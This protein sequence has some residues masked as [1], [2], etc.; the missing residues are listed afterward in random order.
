[1]PFVPDSSPEVAPDLGAVR[2]ENISPEDETALRKK[3]Q[4]AP[5]TSGFIPD[6]PSE[7]SGFLET[8]NPENYVG[9]EPGT[10][11]ART[12]T[13]MFHRAV[14]FPDFWKPESW[15]KREGESA[16]D[17]RQRTMSYISNVLPSAVT[18]SFKDVISGSRKFLG[19]DFAKMLEDSMA[20]M[21]AV[22]GSM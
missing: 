17:H 21:P 11:L 3:L 15:K 4:L 20:M 13:E 10:V 22:P 5:K 6:A 14:P 9:N 18:D 19:D 12:A 8:L 7:K 1:M 16:F 2:F